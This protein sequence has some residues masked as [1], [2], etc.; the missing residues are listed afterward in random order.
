[1]QTDE[2]LKRLSGSIEVQYADQ[3]ESRYSHI[4]T[5]D[6][7]LEAR[8]VFLPKSAEELSQL[9][10][11]CNT[12]KLSVVVHGGLTNLVGATQTK[13]S[14]I[15]VALEKMN[16]IIE[17]D[18]ES[19]TIAV[20]AGVILES[21]HTYL[22][23]SDL[24][25]PLNFGAKGSAQLGGIISSNAG[26]LRVFRYGVTRQL[27]LGLEVVTADGTVISSMKA[28]QK[29]NTGYDLKQLFIG[30]EGTLGVITKA[31][32][33]LVPRPQSRVSAFLAIEKYKHVL[34]VLSKM[35][36]GL[37]GRLT[38]YELIWGDTYQI[39]TTPPASPKPPL[40]HGTAY[41]VLVEL[42]GN[43]Q[44]IESQDLQS[45]LEE[46]LESGLITDAT[47]TQT[48][49]DLNWFW[50]IREDVHVLAKYCPYDQHFDISL[51]P[52]KIGDY[53]ERTTKALYAIDGVIKVFTF[54]HIADGN[55]HFIIGKKTPE[56]ELR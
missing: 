46:F 8:A 48:S 18:K 45:L 37:A 26:G 20:E 41:Y 35:E 9:L 29:D 49:S 43:D 21:I 39:M 52:V 34:Q 27:V 12:H 24:M 25:F 19:K 51:P 38:G 44:S 56:D 13:K 6:K 14:D 33:K 42:M 50:R 54:G 2:I 5:M 16:K 36:G 23:D 47:I 1:M 40:P 3:L 31:I 53:V 32:L 15:V 7:P 4:W 17:L 30:A 28:L 10:A 22:K 55:I 11:F